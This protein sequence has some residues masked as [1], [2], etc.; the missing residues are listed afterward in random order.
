M[1]EHKRDTWTLHVF[2]IKVIV[3]RSVTD[4][5]VLLLLLNCMHKPSTE[6][7]AYTEC[8]SFLSILQSKGERHMPKMPCRKIKRGVSELRREFLNHSRMLRRYHCIH[9]THTRIFISY[10]YTFG[11]AIDAYIYIIF[12]CS[13]HIHMCDCVHDSVLCIPLIIGNMRVKVNRRYREKE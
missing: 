9:V 6:V 10:A 2:T 11:H 5:A 3:I 8:L 13:Y 7:S 1:V 4:K 12:I